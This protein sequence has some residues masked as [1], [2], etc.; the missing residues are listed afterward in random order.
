MG[1]GSA[2]GCVGSGTGGGVTG[3][4]TGG[5]VGGATGGASVTGGAGVGEGAGV[6]GV[7]STGAV[8]GFGAEGDGAEVRGGEGFVSPFGAGL[9]DAV[10]FGA[11]RVGSARCVGAEEPAPSSSASPD[12]VACPASGPVPTLS[13]AVSRKVWPS[14]SG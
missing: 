3:S 12:A 10:S 8:P 11:S 1:A 5:V 7:G 9:C 14:S 13:S 2:G 4:G 6:G